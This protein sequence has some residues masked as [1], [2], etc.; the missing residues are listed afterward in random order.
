[1]PDRK[2]ILFGA[3]LVI[4][5]CGPTVK[6]EAATSSGNWRVSTVGVTER[7]APLLTV[8]NGGFK[9]RLVGPIWTIYDISWNDRR[10]G[11]PFGG[12]GAVVQWEKNDPTVVQDDVINWSKLKKMLVATPD[13]AVSI[14]AKLKKLLLRTREDSQTVPPEVL[15]ALNAALRDPALFEERFL[16]T[17]SLDNGTRIYV[18]REFRSLL[19]DPGQA[20][21]YNRRL[22]DWAWPQY[23]RPIRQTIGTVHGGEDVTSLTLMVDDRTTPLDIKGNHNLKFQGGVSGARISLRKTSVIGPFNHEAEFSFGTPGEF[24]VFHRFTANAEMTRGHFAGYRYAFMFMMPEN[25][26]GWLALGSDGRRERFA[27]EAKAGLYGSRPWRALIAYASNWQTGVV[28]A[29]PEAYPGANHIDVR[30]GKDRK[31]RTDLFASRY[32]VGQRAEFCLLVKP[33]EAS[34]EAWQEIGAA[35]AEKFQPQDNMKGKH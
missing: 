17:L 4:A 12:T 6:T 34:P 23:I 21:M 29:Y 25:F 24:V 8:E 11:T 14:N 18:K 30:I 32:D 22:L 31:F 7:N 5:V 19:N 20:S 28:Y 27:T 15:T 9:V 13:D 26:D 2:K 1:M 10:V 33:F 3:A 16:N 35:I